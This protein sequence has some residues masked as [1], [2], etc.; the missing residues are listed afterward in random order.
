[1]AD[2]YEEIEALERRVKVQGVH[3]QQV[4]LD[5]DDE[6]GMGDHSDLPMCRKFLQLR[7]LHEQSQPLEQLDRVIEDIIRLMVDPAGTVSKERLSSRKE[8]AAA[9]KQ[10]QQQIDGADEQLQRMIW[11]PGG[12]QHRIWEA[13][14]QELM[15]SAAE[16]YDAGASLHISQPASH[17]SKFKS[18]VEE[19]RS[20]I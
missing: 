15:N 6:E 7:R 11:D 19:R 5:A 9:R 17:V 2:L 18:C 13:H 12:F 8:A 10:Q 4:K 1:L 16:E 20:L 14:E 3:I